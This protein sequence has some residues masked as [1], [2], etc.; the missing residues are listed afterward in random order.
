M[1]INQ[2]GNALAGGGTTFASEDDPELVKAAA[3]F[4]LK[5]MESL[6]AETPNHKALLSA[7]SS[8]FTQYAYAF[9]EQQA[10][11][12]EDKDLTAATEM[13]LRAKKLYLRARNYGL[14]ALETQHHGFTNALRQNPKAAVI[15]AKRA[16]VPL[17]F[18]TAVSW[19]AAV[20]LSKDDPNLLA[21]LPTV[22]ALIDRALELQEDFNSGAIHSFLIA[23]EMSRAL[24]PN[25]AEERSR[26]H[27]GRAVQLSGGQQAG[28]FVALAESVSVQKQ[29]AAEFKDLLSRALAI[30]PDARPKWRLMNL[31]MQRRAKWLLSR[32]DELF[33]TR[34]SENKKAE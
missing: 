16:D 17:L 28:P 29:N 4:S 13:R 19:G 26:E 27:F 24:A 25:L 18:W 31:V 2:L 12:L 6:L 23:L 15:E 22:E 9:V 30:N 21:D 20:S 8:G 3:P 33:L 34:G 32:T 11:E 7:A 14:R 5:L 10:D 1:A